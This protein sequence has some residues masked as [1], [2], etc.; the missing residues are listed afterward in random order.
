MIL[1]SVSSCGYE[2]PRSPDAST[3]LKEEFVAR[4]TSLVDLTYD[5]ETHQYVFFMVGYEGS[6]SH[7][8]GC[9]YCK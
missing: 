8:A 2:D 1:L 5:G 7:W 9:K 4:H 3:G 6:V